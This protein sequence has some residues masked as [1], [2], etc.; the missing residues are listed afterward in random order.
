MADQPDLNKLSGVPQGAPEEPSSEKPHLNN[1]PS[2]IAAQDMALT[3]VDDGS[4]FYNTPLMAGTP[5]HANASDAVTSTDHSEP[6]MPPKSA[7]VIPGLSIVN[8]SLGAPQPVDGTVNATKNEAVSANDEQMVDNQPESHGKIDET[9]H[10]IERMNIEERDDA[11]KSGDVMETGEATNGNTVNAGNTT[12]N[13]ADSRDEQAMDQAEDHAPGAQAEVEGED[14]E[15]HPEWE[16]DSSPIESSSDSSDSSDD[17]SDDED[18]EDYPILSAEETA[19]ILM[20][21]EAGSDDEEK[22]GSGGAGIRTTNEHPEEVLPIPDITVTP[23]MKVVHLGHVET[24]V[25]NVVLIRATVSG[26]YQV[27]ESGSLL[28]LEDRTLIGLVADTLGRVEE[29]LYTVRFQGR[30]KIDEFGL[31][32]GKAIFYIES[33]STFV[34]TQPLKGLK[35]SDASNFHDEE[36]GEDEIEFSD[37][38]AEAEY[39]RRLKQKR[40]EKKGESGGFGR[41]RREPPGPSKLGQTELN[42]DDEAG[43]GEDG[44]T[45]LARPKDFHEMMRHQEAPV[46]GA[47]YSPSRGGFRGGRGRGS[48]G[49]DRG[50]GR[51][52]GGGRGR[53]DNRAAGSWDSHGHNNNHSQYSN[54]QPSYPP[55]GR[56]GSGQGSP[57][58]LP[59]YHPQTSAS[60][61]QGQQQQPFAYNAGN[62]P[63]QQFAPYGLYPQ[64]QQPPPQSYGQVAPSM[65]QFP[66]LPVQM[67]YQPNPYSQFPAGAHINPAFFA[68]LQQQQQTAP[69]G[70]ASAQGQNPSTSSVFDQVKAQLEILRQLNGGGGGAPPPGGSSGR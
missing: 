13:G 45:P 62:A 14:E 55:L 5:V 59:T 57:A 39:R 63:T 61:Y 36:V 23:D 19:R 53:G 47:Q 4:D 21:A 52:R 32:Q 66:Q 64:Q 49:F 48:R 43:A 70:A 26:E 44:Y 30:E 42:Y 37:D 25:E 17:S 10:G 11:L 69:G 16:I 56:E 20:Q 12:V 65:P 28:C 40:R 68:A 58:N 67:P 18:E 9:N 50:S 24:I 8:D 35:G 1:L 2:S 31:S 15:E 7:T 6:A 34:F 60:P 29:P 38:E 3:P 22:A 54:R 51:G 41:P 46:E 27:L 33:H